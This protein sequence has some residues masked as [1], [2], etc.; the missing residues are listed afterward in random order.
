MIL[1]CLSQSSQ[2]FFLQAE[3]HLTLDHLY[4]LCMYSMWWSLVDFTISGPYQY[5]CNDIC[6]LARWHDNVRD[7]PHAP[8]VSSKRLQWS[9]LTELPLFSWSL[10][11]SSCKSL[12]A[13]QP[14]HSDC[15]QN[16]ITLVVPPGQL[17]C[18]E[19]RTRTEEVTVGGV[20]RKVRTVYWL[21]CQTPVCVVP[22]TLTKCCQWFKTNI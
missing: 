16:T 9:V 14:K 10:L 7:F 22:W 13:Q 4:K 20:C 21:C 6:L 18:A 12:R 3:A 11:S 8:H 19:C 2:S 5:T 17:W 15:C 1:K